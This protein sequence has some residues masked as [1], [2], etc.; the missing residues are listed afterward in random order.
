MT[1]NVFSMFGC[2]SGTRNQPPRFVTGP[3]SEDT[4]VK[5]IYSCNYWE[6]C[7]I[8][9]HARDF[10]IDETGVEPTVSP[11]AGEF[12]LVQSSDRMSIRH[13]YTFAKFPESELSAENGCVGNGGVPFEGHCLHIC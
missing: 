2:Y 10:V 7:A 13:A 6:E 4:N 11:S 9:L 5:T 1:Q 8:T 3:D 12:R